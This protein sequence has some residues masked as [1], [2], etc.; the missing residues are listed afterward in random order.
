MVQWNENLF[1]KKTKVKLKI[2]EIKSMTLPFVDNGDYYV[3]GE[4]KKKIQLTIIND[5]AIWNERQKKR[6]KNRLANTINQMKRKNVSQFN[7]DE[8]INQ[9]VR[10]QLK[11]YIYRMTK[12][13]MECSKFFF[14]ILFCYNHVSQSASLVFSLI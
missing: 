11:H 1:G 14:R 8:E 6:E 9:K 7:N 2:M 3:D 4:M 12:H 10:A 5:S 13:K